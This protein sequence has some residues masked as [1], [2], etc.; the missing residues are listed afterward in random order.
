[1]K[2]MTVSPPAKVNLLLRVLAREESGYH[3]IETLFQAIDLRDR[4]EIER[5]GE[6][7]RLEVTGAKLGPVEENLVWRAASAFR[8]AAGIDEGVRLRLEKRIPAGA[9]LGGGSSDAAATLLGL[10]RLHDGPLSQEALLA[11]A[12]GLGSDVPFFLSPSPIALGW[13]RGDRLLPLSPFSPAWIVLALPPVAVDTGDAYRALAERRAASAGR[14][15]PAGTADAE[16]AVGDAGGGAEIGGAF[17]TAHILPFNFPRDW[18]AIAARAAN[19]FEDVIFERHPL[20]GKIR[21]ALAETE[22]H[23]S[24]LS[25]SG[26]ALFAL[27]PTERQAEAARADLSSTFPD[28][29][30]QV[31]RTLSIF[32]RS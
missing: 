11:L 25:G 7:V 31:V 28:V 6:D 21:A 27:F 1:M 30:F 12:S 3:Q 5:G 16:G 20:L 22:P 4:L 10:N 13:G 2:R 17:G 24:L 26:A 15:A 18:Q 23:F 29:P 19:D 32:D 8:T 14:P 9:G